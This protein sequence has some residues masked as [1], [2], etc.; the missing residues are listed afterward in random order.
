MHQNSYFISLQFIKSFFFF[1]CLHSS[2]YTSS[3]TFRLFPHRHSVCLF[4]FPSSVNCPK[5]N[6][7]EIKY[8][9]Y[10]IICVNIALVQYLNVLQPVND[11]FLLASSKVTLI[12]NLIGD[13]I[14]RY[15][16]V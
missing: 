5:I 9:Q 3:P 12:Y 6:L 1:S 7:M 15:F 8:N 13:I 2:P 10:L 14:D 4:R 11:K 16:Y